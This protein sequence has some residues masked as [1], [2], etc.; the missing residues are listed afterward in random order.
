VLEQ[1]CQA[2]GLKHGRIRRN[3][4]GCWNL[5]YCGM[6]CAT[7]AKQ[8]MLVTTIPVRWHIRLAC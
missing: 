1:G 8:S 3:V 4:R 5:G 2:L 7:N 6:G